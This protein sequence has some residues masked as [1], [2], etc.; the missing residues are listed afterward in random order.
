MGSRP[1]VGFLI[2][3]SAVKMARFIGLFFR[4]PFSQSDALERVKNVALRSWLPRNNF[5]RKIPVNLDIHTHT[6]R[7][8][9]G[10]GY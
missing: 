1:F 4:L 8:R 10:I 9:R 2:G 7:Q 6:H 3:G 5:S